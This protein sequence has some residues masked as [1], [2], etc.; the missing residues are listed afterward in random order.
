MK[1]YGVV[2]SWTKLYVIDLGER[3]G[4]VIGFKKNGEVL[5]TTPH[6]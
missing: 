1:E 3:L 2:E 5:V 4:R 6:S